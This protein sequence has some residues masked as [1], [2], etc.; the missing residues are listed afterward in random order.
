[1]LNGRT[2]LSEVKK[3]QFLCPLAVRVLYGVGQ[4][5]EQALQGGGIRTVS[6][7][8]SDSSMY[9]S[10]QFPPLLYLPQ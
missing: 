5:T 7:K 10:S 8:G 9:S 6:E 1:M 4:I 3:I 2:V